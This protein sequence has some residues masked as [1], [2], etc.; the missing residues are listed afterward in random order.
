MHDQTRAEL[1]AALYLREHEPGLDHETLIERID[2]EVYGEKYT[3]P[4]SPVGL[5]LY[6]T[7]L[8]G[9][10][11]ASMFSKVTLAGVDVTEGF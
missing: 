8:G 6:Q 1:N 2:L 7:Y 3:N 9:I 5:V 4:N 10:E 11:A